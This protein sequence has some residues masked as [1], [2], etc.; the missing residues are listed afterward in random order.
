MTWKS[1]AVVSGATVLVGWLA[2]SP[3][4]TAPAS[5][6]PAQSRTVAG[7]PAATDIEQQ[8][9]RLQ[10][11]LRQDAVY[12]E[13]ER[14]PFRFGPSRSLPRSEPEAAAP[15]LASVPPPPVPSIALSGVAEDQVGDRPERT[16]V[17]SSP[18]GV[19]L[20][21]EGD[22]VLDLYRVVSIERDAVELVTL[23]DGVRIRLS[24]DAPRG[25]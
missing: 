1:T 25:R 20:V 22:V 13:P 24:L 10:A 16:A 23:A 4:S 7:A 8:A 6:T 19:L 5:S 15:P 3:P 14:N 17:L 21:Q 2:S 18:S 11:G 12:R 9:T